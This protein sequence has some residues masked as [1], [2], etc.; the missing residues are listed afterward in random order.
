MRFFCCKMVTGVIRLYLMDSG[1]NNGGSRPMSASFWLTIFERFN[2]IGGRI[3]IDAS[4]CADGRSGWSNQSRQPYL[5]AARRFPVR[6]DFWRNP[7][8]FGRISPAALH[9]FFPKSFVRVPM[10]I[11]GGCALTGVPHLFFV[12]NS[13]LDVPCLYSAPLRRCRPGLGANSWLDET[14]KAWNGR[15]P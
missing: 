5:L 4:L 15:R 7:S 11:S 2:K 3:Q 9:Q 14:G 8:D 6:A 1:K 10:C 13:T 12:E